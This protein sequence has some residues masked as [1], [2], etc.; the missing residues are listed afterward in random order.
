MKRL[1]IT[2]TPFDKMHIDNCIKELGKDTHF[3]IKSKI[4]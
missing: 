3:L 1:K 2:D 4:N